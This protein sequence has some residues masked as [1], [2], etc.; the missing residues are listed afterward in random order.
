MA[1]GPARQQIDG[2]LAEEQAAGERRR[3]DRAAGGHADSVPETPRRARQ[4]QARFGAASRRWRASVVG[5]MMPVSKKL[6][7][8]C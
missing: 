5:K 8:S 7:L 6:L 2:V 3:R 1:N 4:R